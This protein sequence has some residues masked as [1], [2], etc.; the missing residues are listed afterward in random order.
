M[1]DLTFDEKMKLEK[2]LEMGSGYVLNFSNRTFQEFVH[3]V[4][5]KDAYDPKYGRGSKAS[6]LRAFF[7]VEPNYAV[8]KLLDSLLS[9]LKGYNLEASKNPLFENCERTAQRLLQSAP[10]QDIDAIGS[11]SEEREFEV[12]SN[13][14]REA[15]NRNEPETG[16]DRLHTYVLKYM[17]H[18]CQKHGIDTDREKPL[19]S[20]VGEY[21]KWLRTEGLL[22]SEMAERI[23]KSTISIMEAFNHVRNDQSLAHDNPVLNYN[24]S[25]LILSH[26]TSSIKFIRALEERADKRGSPES[27]VLE[28][29]L[30]IPF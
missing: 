29:S 14:I 30:D 6:I 5:G 27:G 21:I 10:V 12:L 19:H 26:V 4:T 28:E 9:H 18:L 20:L 1:S 17:R 24:E 3:E 16:L 2:V 11:V 8:G 15:I 13:S 7:K 25:L 22:E 23:L